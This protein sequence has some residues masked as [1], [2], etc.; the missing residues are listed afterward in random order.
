MPLSIRNRTIGSDAPL[1]VIAELGLNHGGSLS[2][3]LAL[4]DA[5]AAAGA[6]A[7]KLQTLRGER[8]V[9]PHCPAPMHV[10]AASLVD[11]FKQ[12]ELDEPAH[13]LVAARARSRGLAVISTPFD[14][15]AVDLLER[16]GIDAYK[17]ASGDITFHQLIARAAATGK[18]LIISTGMSGLQEIRDALDCARAAGAADIALMHCVSAYPVPSGSENLRAIATLAGTFDVPIGLSDH[19]AFSEAAVIATALGASLYERHL[20]LDRSAGSVDAA[21]SSTPEELSTIIE[22]AERA[23]RALG[24]GVKRCLAAEAGNLHASRRGLYAARTLPQGHVV[25][26]DDLVALRPNAAVDARAWRTVVGCTVTERIEQG[27]AFEPAKL[28]PGIQG[29]EEAYAM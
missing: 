27:Q 13:A 15:D 25:S 19:G 29:G 5:A 17:I 26:E 16:V 14:L 12:F 8:L 2:Q 3:A 23:R 10:E 28:T 9:A 4:V 21:V 20:D 22:M 24:D 11:F 1:Y 18:P 6:S 7:I